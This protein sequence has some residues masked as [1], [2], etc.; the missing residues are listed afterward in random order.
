[1]MESFSEFLNNWRIN[2]QKTVTMLTNQ[3]WTEGLI[4]KN[5]S[6]VDM[7]VNQNSQDPII[8]NGE[9]QGNKIIIIILNGTSIGYLCSK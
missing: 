8:I 6:S 4:H 9:A 3:N 7:I 2:F 1:M 5:Q